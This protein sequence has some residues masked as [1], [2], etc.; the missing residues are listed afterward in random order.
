MDAQ[1][2]KARERAAIFW[3][4]ILA[5]CKSR[6]NLNI[7]LRMQIQASLVCR[8][9]LRPI[10][11]A[12]SPKSSRASFCLD[13]SASGDEHFWSR[14]FNDL[15]LKC[16]R[17]LLTVDEARTGNPIFWHARAFASKRPSTVRVV[18]AAALQGRER[19]AQTAGA[20]IFGSY[21]RDIARLPSTRSGAKRS[22]LR[23]ALRRTRAPRPH[24]RSSLAACRL[25]SRCCC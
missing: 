18:A 20:A 1:N 14:I 11:C 19:N 23:P 2:A 22:P 21:A 8:L 9:A 4:T 15:L 10:E 7:C 25:S 3:R 16:V 12:R 5:R 6:L 24:R 17:R 13:A